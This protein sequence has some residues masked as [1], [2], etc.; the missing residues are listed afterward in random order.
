[1]PIRIASLNHD[2]LG[3]EAKGKVRGGDYEQVMIPAVE[4]AKEWIAKGPRFPMGKPSVSEAWPN[5]S[6]L[7][8]WR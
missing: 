5:L 2:V 1:M 4:A 3:F 6:G 7:T 8:V